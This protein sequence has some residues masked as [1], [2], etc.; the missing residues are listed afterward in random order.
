MHI[1]H[2]VTMSNYLWDLPVVPFSSYIGYCTSAL[3]QG[4]CD[5]LPPV[6]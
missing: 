4:S 1:V 3:L 6:A 5:I 2:D